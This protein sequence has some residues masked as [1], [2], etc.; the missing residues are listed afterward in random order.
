MTLTCAGSVPCAQGRLHVL[1]AQSLAG[2]GAGSRAGEVKNSPRWV[3]GPD[4]SSL[5]VATGV[6]GRAL[7][8]VREPVTING[9]RG[10]AHPTHWAAA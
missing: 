3:Q 5:V 6:L 9:R 4:G 7:D 8:A 1:A 10:A 2:G